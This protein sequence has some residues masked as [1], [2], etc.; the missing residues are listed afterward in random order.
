MLDRF[1]NWFANQLTAVSLAISTRITDNNDGW[2]SLASNIPHD[3]TTAE[4]QQLYVDVLTAWRK[5]PLAWRAIQTITD[6]VVG[7]EITISSPLPHLQRFIDEFWDH[8][9]NHM[10]T[11]LESMSDELSRAGDLFVVLARNNHN[12]MSYIRFLTKDDIHGIIT[13]A[14]D[15]EIEMEYHQTDINQSDGIKR[16]YSPHNGRSQRSKD[17]VLH[18]AINQP[19]GADFGESDLATVVPWLLRYSRMLEDR[20]RLHW[21]A[22]A[23][24]WFVKVPSTKVAAKKEQY[25][26]PPEPGSIIVHD[27]SEEWKLETPRLQGTDARPDLKATRG[28]IDAGTGQP[29]HWRGEGEDV[30]HATADA[31]QAPTEKHLKRRQNYFVWMLQDIL[32]H[33]YTRA[34]QQ[35]PDQWPALD[36]HSYKLLFTANT[37]DISRTDNESLAS[38]ATSMTA[39]LTQLVE[40]YPSPTLKR[41]MLKAVLTTA[42]T[43]QPDEF[44]DQVM[45]ESGESD[46]SPMD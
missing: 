5:N 34:H 30:N 41:Q 35:H 7:D 37:P 28:M 27:D 36:T 40:Q 25:R 11:R 4:H 8:P 44:I 39:V 19:I 32:Y 26:T 17:I 20:I 12:G 3:R 15:W 45:Q 22:R 33:A 29:P 14:N 9:L 24:L 43:P 21:A 38:A 16:W 18:Y 42:G 46:A 13:K 6:Y 2:N 23:F 31:M 10:P 1:R